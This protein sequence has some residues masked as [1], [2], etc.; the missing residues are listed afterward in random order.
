MYKIILV[1]LVVA[2]VKA[3]HYGE[4]G[5]HHGVDY[6]AEPHYYFQYE[7]KDDHTGDFKSHKEERKGDH[8]H[9][10]Y[11][12]AQPDGSKRVV[13]YSV[14]G[15]HGG[16][17]PKVHRDPVKHI[18]NKG[19]GHGVSVANQNFH[20]DGV[21][22]VN[23]PHGGFGGGFGNYHSGG[24]SDGFAGHSGEL[25]AGSYGRLNNGGHNDI[26]YNNGGYSNGGA[27][28]SVSLSTNG[29]KIYTSTKHLAP[30]GHGY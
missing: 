29:A 21:Y 9:G 16:F 15:K 28:S 8:T 18:D 6:Y 24:L 3:Q 11:T 19:H 27:S 26:G 10:V 4:H 30:H 20:Q 14:E 12:V 2:G 25:S 5:G 7:V 23:H 22:E 17:V 13:E 1:G